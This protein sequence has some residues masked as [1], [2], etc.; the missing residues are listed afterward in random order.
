MSLSPGKQFEADIKKSVPD[1]C[2]LYRFKDSASSF[3]DATN[4]SFTPSNICDYLMLDDES[5]TLY[6][7]ELKTHKGTSLPFSAI[8]QS[9][10]KQMTDAGK[11]NLVTGFMINLRE[12]D[13]FTAFIRIDDFN[14]MMEE[15]GKKSCNIKDIMDYGGVKIKSEKKRTSYRYDLKDFIEKTHL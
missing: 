6:F 14:R 15:T 1:S 10:I 12:K 2:Y 5:R 11:H 7:L 4:T 9:Q 13:N 3:S 8:R